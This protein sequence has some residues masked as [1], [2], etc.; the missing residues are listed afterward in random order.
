MSDYTGPDHRVTVTVTEYQTLTMPSGQWEEHAEVDHDTQHPADCDRLKYGE[1]CALDVWLNDSGDE[2]SGMPMEAGAYLVRYWGTGPD[3][4]GEY[5]CG[6]TVT[7][8]P[9]EQDRSGQEKPV[10]QGAPA[11]K[12]GPWT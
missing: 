9:A 5:D 7:G 6:L 4:N 8:V 2:Y 11:E 1:M 10:V 3:H 12:E